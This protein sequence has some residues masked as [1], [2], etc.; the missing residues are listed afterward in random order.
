M[1]TLLFLALFA[2]LFG[3]IS[4]THSV[5]AADTAPDPERLHIESMHKHAWFLTVAIASLAGW[6]LGAVKGFSTSA[7]WMKK[8]WKSPPALAVFICDLFIF[9]VVGA[10]FG[11][12]IYD[13]TSF[14]SA[15]AAGLSWPL[16][17]GALAT[18]NKAPISDNTLHP[19][20]KMTPGGGQ[21]PQP[22][23]ATG[24]GH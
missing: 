4:F 21:E 5:S 2:V 19:D 23:P 12:G 22:A 16:G 11:T 6:V 13:P 20:K 24:G 3:A 9:V 14:V 8:Y 1:A 17:L 10:Y 18:P 15:L 7:D